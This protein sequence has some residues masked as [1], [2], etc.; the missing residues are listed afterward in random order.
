MGAQIDDGGFVDLIYQTAVEPELW[1]CLL[2]RFAD[3]IGGGGAALISQNQESGAGAGVIARL[4]PAAP[5][6]YFGHFA[7]RNPIQ[8]IDNPRDTVKRFVPLVLT[9][10][11]RMPKA[12]LMRT[13][14]YNDFMRPFDMHSFVMLGLAM[15]GLNGASVN[16]AR[17]RA[18]GGFSQAD[19][20]AARR[21]HPHF[22]RAWG[23]G[24][25]VAAARLLN[26]GMADILDHSPHGMFLLG[27]DGA[28][29]H[30]NRAAEA[31]VAAGDALTVAGG[32]LVAVAPGATQKL[33]ALIGAAAT[34]DAERRSGGSMALVSPKRRLPL[35]VTVAPVRS[36]RFSMLMNGPAVMV[37]VT[38]LEAAVSLP[39]QRLR[40]LFGLSRAEARVAL[41]L[42]EGADPRAAA[43]KLEVSFHTVRG[44]LVRIFD[45]T[46]TTGQVDWPG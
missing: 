20:A 18:R 14:Y 1:P 36:E 43:A 33:Q 29:R 37:C 26:A 30:L 11:H 41:A 10:E 31:L 45:K 16:I 6:L 28:V 12:A 40:D 35:S 13:E 44:H 46:Q 27:G 19:L 7:S 24:R 22:I 5:G 4:D 2:E 15:D 21:F 8:R 9:D 17:P 32:R 23:L 25:K 34:S 42:F 3:R 38:D 39:E